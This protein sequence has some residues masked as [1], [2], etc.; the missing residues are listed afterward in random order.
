MTIHLDRIHKRIMQ[1]ALSRH[2]LSIVTLHAIAVQKIWTELVYQPGLTNLS[3]SKPMNRLNLSKSRS[4]Y[5]LPFMA[6]FL[7]T[8]SKVLCN[9]VLIS[10]LANVVRS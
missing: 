7:F 2:T 8:L 3:Y 1:H 5:R 9:A 6:C 10:P 4:L